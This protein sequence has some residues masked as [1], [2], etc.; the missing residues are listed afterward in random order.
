MAGILPDGFAS[1]CQGRRI[2]QEFCGDPRISLAL[3]EIRL[4]LADLELA[5][6]VQ[7]FIRLIFLDLLEII[8]QD[9]ARHA[10]KNDEIEE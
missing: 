6:A 1:Q 4:N 2:A 5:D 8:D 10:D 3:V 7:I 9:I